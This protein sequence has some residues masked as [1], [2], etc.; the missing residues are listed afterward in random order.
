[1]IGLQMKNPMISKKEKR[2]RRKKEW[3]KWSRNASFLWFMHATVNLDKQVTIC[4]YGNP[5][6]THTEI[7]IKHTRV[8]H[9]E[10]H[11]CEPYTKMLMAWSKY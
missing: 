10:T 7:P 1:M 9:T 4:D 3:N 5:V 11:R 8:S 6:E 2:R